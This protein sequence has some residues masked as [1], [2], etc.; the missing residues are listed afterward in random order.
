[1]ST[2][3]S[4]EIHEQ[5]P[6]TEVEQELDRVKRELTQLKQE[7]DLGTFGNTSV[8]CPGEFF[9]LPANFSIH[10]PGVYGIMPKKNKGI[11]P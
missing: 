7:R 9:F 2:G 1:L 4:G 8:Q 11:S 3:R 10:F 5:R 6:L